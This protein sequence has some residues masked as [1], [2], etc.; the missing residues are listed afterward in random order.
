MRIIEEGLKAN[1][2]DAA[3]R[4]SA[5]VALKR[6]RTKRCT[7]A[8]EYI[9]QISSDANPLDVF[10]QEVCNTATKYLKELS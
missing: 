4:E 8:L 2:F 6:L 7:L 3:K 9:M 10:A 5:R 1:I